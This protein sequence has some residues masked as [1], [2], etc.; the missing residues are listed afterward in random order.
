MCIIKEHFPKLLLNSTKLRTNGI[1][2]KKSI[3]ASLKQRSLGRY[4]GSV[5]ITEFKQGFA[6]PVNISLIKV[7]NRKARKR[8]EICSKLTLKAGI[9]SVNFERISHR[10]LFPLLILNR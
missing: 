3:I 1:L 6:Q 5:F 2:N 10:F 8:R 4:S 7:N 9:F